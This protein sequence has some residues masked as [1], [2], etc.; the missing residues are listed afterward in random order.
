MN[1]ENK[2]EGYYS[3][4]RLDLVRLIQR[5]DKE[6]KVLEIG[7]AYGETL[8][9]I[10]NSGIA[11]EVVGVDLFKDEQHPERYKQL[12][13]FIF[14]DIQSLNMEQYYNYFDVIL[15]PDVLEHIIE[16]LPVLEK[17]KQMIKQE[18]EIIIS[19]PNIRHFSA[20]VKIFIK[21]NFEYQ[22]S[23]IFDFTHMRFY[24]KSD[25]IRLVEK[26]NYK[27]QLVEGSIKNY[28]KNSI[29][30]IIN[31]LTFGFFEEFFS[32]QYF[33]KVKK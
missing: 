20:F 28:D 9:Y 3:N 5:K 14:G 32:I 23:G 4:I 16:P 33:V 22:D 13:N 6:L 17:V 11:S 27:V 1:Y 31:R 8:Y 26:A 30:K 12:D 18:G 2:L 29:T 25:L 24:C 15:L 10:K 7:A 21:G 19:V